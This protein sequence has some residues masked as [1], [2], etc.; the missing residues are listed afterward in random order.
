M[1]EMKRDKEESP[2]YMQLRNKLKD[3]IESGKYKH[4]DKLPSERELAEQFNISRM[5][6]RHTLSILERE[7]VVERSIGVGTFITN[8]RIKMDFI[9]FNS[10]S[11]AMLSKWFKPTNKKLSK[12]NN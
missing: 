1:H 10:F 7:G 8:N 6:A 4:G 9:N 5:T 12:S 11:K 3:D 2:F